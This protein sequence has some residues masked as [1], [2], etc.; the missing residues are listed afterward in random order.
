MKTKFNS[1]WK[2]SKQPRKQRKYVANAPLHQKKNFVKVNVSKELRKKYGKRNMVVKKGDTIKV[3]RGKFK[4]KQGKVAQVQ[5]K[6]AK[7]LVDGIQIKKQ[8]GSKINSPLRASNLQIVELNL[9]TRKLKT[10]KKSEKPIEKSNEKPG[11][12]PIGVYPK[13]HKPQSTKS[14][15]NK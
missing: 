9:D 14:R 13:G 1:T 5:M 6:K 8:D 10:E 15:S 7:I 11:D 3:M 2:A 12:A 4:K